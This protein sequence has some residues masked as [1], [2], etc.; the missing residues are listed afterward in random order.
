[1]NKGNKNSKKH[2]HNRRKSPEKAVGDQKRSATKSL[3]VDEQLLALGPLQ[4]NGGKAKNFELYKKLKDLQLKEKHGEMGEFITT[5]VAYKP[6]RP[7]APVRSRQ[8]KYSDAVDQS[9]DEDE[10]QADD[11][12][13]DSSGKPSSKSGSKKSDGKSSKKQSSSSS[14][15]ITITKKGAIVSSSA[16]DGDDDDDDEDFE[17]F[18][19]SED[20]DDRTDDDDS[21]QP[22]RDGYARAFKCYSD[23]EFRAETQI[24]NERLQGYVKKVDE[25]RSTNVKII[26]NL[27]QSISEASR[28]KIKEKK[29][30]KA[31]MKAKDALGYWRLIC[32]VH[33]NLDSGDRQLDDYAA[34]RDYRAIKQHPEEII[35]VYYARYCDALNN[36]M[37][38]D[39]PIEYSQKRIATHFIDSLSDKYTLFRVMQM[40]NST[41]G[42]LPYPVTLMEAY[43]RAATWMTTNSLQFT[44]YDM[45]FTVNTKDKGGKQNKNGSD[46]KKNKKKSS[47]KAKDGVAPNTPS[48]KHRGKDGVLR[49]KRGDII[50]CNNCGGNHFERDCQDLKDVVEDT[51]RASAGK[52]AS[53]KKE[54]AL[55]ITESVLSTLHEFRINEWSLLCDTETTV[56]IIS[57]EELV[58]DIKRSSEP[59]EVTGYGGG[60]RDINLDA[61]T[62]HFGAVKFDPHG[63]YNLIKF[64]TIANLHVVEWKQAVKGT[65]DPHYLWC[66]VMT[67]PHIVLSRYLMVCLCVS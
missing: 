23:R 9:S 38:S 65:S 7:K 49:N 8:L 29:E 60:F 51:I 33:Q 40:N 4:Y 18:D 57:N 61:T 43:D 37:A 34:D 36:A 46:V 53:K 30:Y 66:S 2:Y 26:A 45:A 47:D 48:E 35:T 11:D 67:V 12:A 25:L 54:E 31:I 28:E 21:D 32:Q 62:T 22:P 24:Y 41:S 27:E 1:M 20:E 17:D 64:A 3:S 14:K 44:G 42:I 59:I 19:S 6:D 55:V 39:D 52:V 56:S 5:G 16:G 10:D 63:R 50:D 58:Y 15:K 13:G